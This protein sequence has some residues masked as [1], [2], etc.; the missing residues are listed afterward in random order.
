MAIKVAVAVE[1]PAAMLL[2]QVSSGGN[3][4]QSSATEG[5]TGNAGRTSAAGGRGRGNRSSNNIVS[6]RGGHGR[7]NSDQKVD[8]VAAAIVGT[9]R[10]TARTAAC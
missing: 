7:D 10:R 2:L 1:D 8:R 9:R 5:S 6:G 4:P 3:T